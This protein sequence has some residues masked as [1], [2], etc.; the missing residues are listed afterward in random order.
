METRLKWLLLAL[1]IGHEDCCLLEKDIKNNIW[2]HRNVEILFEC[3]TQ[4]LTSELSEPVRY[5]VD[6]E[7]RNSICPGNHVLVCLL[8]KHLTTKKKMT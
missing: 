7:K 4:Y 6:H 5:Q 1:P 2:A 8:H 3:S